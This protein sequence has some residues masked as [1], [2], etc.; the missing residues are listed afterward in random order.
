MTQTKRLGLVLGLN[1]M[2]IVGLVVVGTASHSLG[3]LAAG[4]D[5]GADSAGIVLG[6]AAIQLRKRFARHQRATTYAALIN[7]TALLIF[8]AFIIASGVHRLTGNAPQVQGLP[9]LI[10]SAIATLVMGAGALIL[11]RDAGSEDLHMRSV[12]LDTV[13]DAVSSAAVAVTGGIIYVTHGTYWLDPLAAILIAL[14]I[15]FGTLRLLRDV[16]TEL[17]KAPSDS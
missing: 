17:R 14:I 16:I 6:I 8:T 3:V 10:V 1:L 13:S 11:G 4:G 2:M 12:L 7:A 9:V 15:G 5:Y